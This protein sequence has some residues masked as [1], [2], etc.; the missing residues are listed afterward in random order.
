MEFAA[1]TS[2][3]I[4][5]QHSYNGE[6][7]TLTGL[8]Y[9]LLDALGNVLV[10]REPVAGFNPATTQTN[11]VVTAANNTTTKKRD[12]RQLKFFMINADGER[13]T[14]AVYM[15]KGDELELTVPTDSFQ[16]FPEAMV[17]RMNM[18]DTLTYYDALTDTQKV[19]ALEAAYLRLQN[20]TF[21]VG[22]VKVTNLSDYTPEAFRA[23]NPKFLA[24][25]QKAQIV[26]ADV[27]VENS[28]VA[29]KIR[30]GIISETIGE[31]SM[32]FRSDGKVIPSKI[33]HLSDRAYPYLSDWIY[34]D[35]ASSQIWKVRRA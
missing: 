28:P 33:P 12:V 3:T 32:F 35:T 10:E 20:L 5:V 6:T 27:L 14:N 23:L 13:I 22:G 29:E 25:L 21:G 2:C 4:T 1:N 26:E 15:L 19:T 30:Q 24:A 8:E 18:P 17:N 7:I 9:I 31:S 34:K 16:T 11:L